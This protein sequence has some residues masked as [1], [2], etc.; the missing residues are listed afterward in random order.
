MPIGFHVGKNGRTMKQALIEDTKIITDFGLKP[1]VQIFTVGPQN[2][3]ETLLDSDKIYIKQYTRTIPLVIHGA[4]IDNPWGASPGGTV[5][6]KKEMEICASIGG[7]GVIIHLGAGAI[8]DTVLSHILGEINTLPQSVKDSCILYLEINAAK[9]SAGTFETPEKIQSL[10][11]RISELNIDLQVGL[12][13]DSAHVFSCGVSFEEYNF[14]MEWLNQLPD[15]PIMFHLN[16]SASTKGSGKDK[17]EQLLKGNI[18]KNYGEELPVRDSGLMAILEWS[19]QNDIMVI[20]ER[21]EGL[22]Q[23]LQLIESLGYFKN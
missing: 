23:D 5:N 17:H 16:D 8:N 7:A 4:Y 18:W 6:I 22:Y 21:G 15:V 19:Q 9:Q 14:T 11:N 12:C 13:V 1:C 10:F 20:L 2:H 3:K